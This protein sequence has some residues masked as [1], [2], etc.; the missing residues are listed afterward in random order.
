M[1]NQGH[2]QH[3]AMKSNLVKSFISD[4]APFI[5]E[6]DDLSR[7]LSDVEDIIP[8]LTELEPLETQ[9]RFKQ[10]TQKLKGKARR[11]LQEKPETWEQMRNLLI[12]E[13]SD[14]MDIGSQIVAMERVGYLGSIYKT[15]EKLLYWQTRM[16]DKIELSSDPAAE[17]ALLKSSVRRRCYMQLR[18]SLPQ[19]CQGALTSR[20]C[21][22]LIDAIK[23][24]HDEDF[25]TYDR[26]YED[27]RNPNRQVHSYQKP[28]FPRPTQNFPRPTQN[29]HP[30]HRGNNSR[31]HTDRR[32]PQ[33]AQRQQQNRNQ[34]HNGDQPNRPN[35]QR[36][37]NT[38]QSQQSRMKKPWKFHRDNFDEP[39]T[40]NAAGDVE[41][42][43]YENFFLT[44]RT[45]PPSLN[46]E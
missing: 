5:G 38:N 34:N 23:I 41:P 25:L 37:N 16:L 15:Y 29:S 7:F 8:P 31:D 39:V 9:I 10:I 27:R 12:R 13:C 20:Q 35:Y 44:P 32:L 4:L 3:Q 18:K 43:E 46:Q 19:A 30:N 24:L 6:Y 17:K 14:R 11:I 42:M 1:E 2:V 22:S 33:P 36:Y 40:Y 28:N 21:S 45:P 26:Y